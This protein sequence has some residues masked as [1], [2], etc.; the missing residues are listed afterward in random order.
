MIF[1]TIFVAKL[2][3]FSQT[4]MKNKSLRTSMRKFTFGLA[5]VLATSTLVGTLSNCKPTKKI[6]QKTQEE[7][8]LATVAGKPINLSDFRYVYE[9]NT[10]KDSLYNE[11]SVRDYLDLYTKFKQKVLDA[12]SVGVDTTQLFRDEFAGYEEQLTRPYMRV[13]NVNDAIVKQAYERLK[14]E[15]NAAHILLEVK[16]DAEP[17][18]TLLVYKKLQEIREK[19]VKGEDFGKLATQYSQDP[20]AKF[21][22]GELGYFTSLQMVYPFEQ[23]AY[24]T[25]KGNISNIVRTNFGYH[26]LKVNDRRNTSG[27]VKVAHIM[28]RT[29]Q[30][31]SKQDSINTRNK[32][33][34][35]YSKAQ[36]GENWDKLCTQFSEDSRTSATGGEMQ[37]FTVGALVP[38]FEN[39][40]FKLQKN[41]DIAEP[42][43]TV[44][45]WHII[46]L[47]DKKGLEPFSELENGLLAKI[48]KDSRADMGRMAFLKKIKAENNFKINEKTLNK[49]YA[50]VDTSLLKGTWKYDKTSPKIVPI[51]GESIIFFNNDKISPET[52]NILAGDFAD[53]LARTQTPRP[54][55][56]DAKYYAK[57]YFERFADD[58]NVEF[59]K[60]N[61]AK[62]YPE[63]RLLS[64]EYREGMMLFQMMNDNVWGK[65]I[66]DSVGAKKF[67]DQSANKYMFGTR[68][69]AVIYD[70]ANVKVLADAK[71]QRDAKSFAVNDFTVS[72]TQFEKGKATLPKDALANLNSI[73]N[74]LNAD[75]TLTLEVGGHVDATEK[76]AISAERIKTTVEYLRSREVKATQIITKDYGKFKTVSRTDAPKNMRVTYAMTSSS[77]KTLEKTINTGNPL[78]LKITEGMFSKGDN[79]FVDAVEWKAGNYTIEKDGRVI[80]IIIKNVDAPRQKV[81]EEA[82][83]QVIT[84]YQ[85]YLEQEWLKD[86]AKRFPAVNNEVEISKIIKK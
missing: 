7:P 77:L 78:N 68:A 59:E 84:E 47:I 44:Y 71:K 64:Q 70:A 20:S 32:I 60:K 5:T 11:K 24:N 49:V 6:A 29:V 51:L 38:S 9:K 13:Q 63:Y 21:N 22:G 18:D 10:K 46:K 82:R 69:V 16:P 35:I 33:Y 31:A 52:T 8:F 17:K 12:Q 80:E 66:K 50:L 25:P 15:V 40:A 26:I 39:A 61:L 43:L 28:V 86:L 58:K 36:K 30:G 14:E 4:I 53:Y 57:T 65:A 72:A 3:K 81:Y 55:L 27:K 45:G 83:G 34:E 41:G 56:K 74:M 37:Y 73:A 42:V 1:C 54:D 75:A 79:T 76:P 19:A 67:F 23:V 62:K 2:N 48:S 85:K